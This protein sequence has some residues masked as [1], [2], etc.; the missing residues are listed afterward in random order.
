M[1]HG[2]PIIV[3]GGGV[4]GI[5]TAYYL[6][7]AGRSVTIVERD[8]LGSGCSHG[9]C[10]L[11]CPSHVLPLAEPGAVKKALKTLNRK[12]SP[13]YIKPRIDP[14]LWLWLWRFA[15]R[16][17]VRDRVSAGHARKPLLDSSIALY[18]ELLEQESLDCEWQE[19]GCLF[20]YHSAQG[21]EAYAETDRMLRD[22]FSVAARRLDGDELLELEP[23]LR[24]GLAGGWFYDTDAHMRPDRLLTAWR[25][26]LDRLEVGVVEHRE[27][28]GLC[29]EG[30]RVSAVE[31]AAATLPASSVVLA[32]GALS[33]RLLRQAGARLDVQPGKG[34]SITT[35]R[36]EPCPTIPLIF[37]EHKVAATPMESGFRLG[38]TMEF[39][40]YDA[41]IDE[42]RVALLEAS[43][44]TYLDVPLGAAVEER[45]CGW[46]PMVPDDIPTIGSSPVLD[47]LVIAAGHGMTGLAMGPATGKL[48]SE[49]ITGAAPHIDPEPYRPRS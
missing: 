47:N 15:R 41:S 27:V 5:A 38:S 29:R 35:S 8:T 1:S 19:R 16:C 33:P 24:P 34:Y 4:V 3:V 28:T 9:N 46:R 10:G 40:G 21:M 37:Q 31:T 26:V 48:V 43:A 22:T 7:R 6:A 49:L 42:G 45:W 44:R 11:V 39:S 36:P 14:R 23:T 20:V 17:N 32:M 2:D 25:G 13:F 18:R 30:R 12:G